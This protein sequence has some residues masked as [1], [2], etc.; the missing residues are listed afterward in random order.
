MIFLFFLGTCSPQKNSNFF[1]KFGFQIVGEF[2]YDG[3]N[4]TCMYRAPHSDN[5]EISESSGMAYSDISDLEIS[6]LSG[7]EESVHEQKTEPKS[8]SQNRTKILGSEKLVTS[9]QGEGKAEPRYGSISLEHS[10]VQKL[11]RPITTKSSENFLSEG[12]KLPSSPSGIRETS[13][14]EKHSNMNPEKGSDGAVGKGSVGR[15]RWESELQR[16]RRSSVGAEVMEQVVVTS[17]M[18]DGL[19]DR[20]LGDEPVPGL[21]ESIDKML[22]GFFENFTYTGQ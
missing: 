2:E 5:S 3:I 6:D 10:R 20:L 21:D 9:I 22:R 8:E 12:I 19:D 4:I 17:M 11:E 1:S 7:S 16:S 18:K 15:L 13:Q 14:H